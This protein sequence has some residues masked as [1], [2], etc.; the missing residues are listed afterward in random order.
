MIRMVATLIAVAFLISGCVNPSV[1][2]VRDTK[3]APA[4]QAPQSRRIPEP[5]KKDA[6]GYRS[7]DSGRTYSL[8]LKNA[9]IKD[10]L[11]LLSKESGVP[12]VQERNLRGSVKIEAQN[13]KL[14]ELLFIILK[15]LGYTATVENGVIMV[16]RPQL[17]TR[18]FQVN[19]LKDRR[20]S[21]SNMNVA[22]FSAGSVSVSTE[23]TSD[24][25]GAIENSLELMVF[26]TSGKGKRESGGYIRGDDLAKVVAE[27]KQEYSGQGGKTSALV[28]SSKQSFARNSDYNSSSQATSQQIERPDSEVLDQQLADNKLKQLLVNEIAGI[29][30]V[31][32][33]PENIDR[34]AAFLADVEEGS[35]RQVMIQAHIMEVSLKDSFSMG[36]DWKYIID[37]ASNFNL[38][39]T[40]APVVAG[41][42][43][44]GSSVFKLSAAGDSFGVLLDAMKEQGNVNMLSSPKITALNNQKAVIKLTTKQ[45]SWVS[46]KTTQNNAIGG[47]DTY[48]TTPQVDEVGIFLDVTPQIGQ[49]N[50]ITMQIHPS[51]SEIKEI[52]TSPDKNSNKP[53]I[54]VREIDTMVDARAGETIVIAG[55]ITDK[56]NETKRSVPLL[57]DIPYLGALF[58]YSKQ[59]RTKAELVI[60]MTPYILNTKTIAEIREE[61]EQR[62]RNMTGSFYLINNLGSMVSEKSSRDFMNSVPTLPPV[63]PA[64]RAVPS[65]SSLPVAAEPLVVAHAAP[66][67]VEPVVIPDV[68]PA[69]KKSEPP[70]SGVKEDRI[71]PPQP[72]I[73]QLPGRPVIPPDPHTIPHPEKQPR[74]TSNAVLPENAD[75]KR[76][77]VLISTTSP[78]TQ[79]LSPSRKPKLSVPS[80]TS[81]TQGSD[82]IRLE[83]NGPHQQPKIVR[84]TRN[85]RVIIQLPGVSNG[86]GDINVPLD[87]LGFNRARVA[88]HSDGTWVVLHVA[89]K[90][91]PRITPR[92]DEQGMTIM[93]APP[94]VAVAPQ[95][96][97]TAARTANAAVLMPVVPEAPAALVAPPPRE[98]EA[99][100]PDQVRETPVMVQ[101]A[102]ITSTTSGSEQDLYRAGVSAYKAGNCS[103]A[104]KQLSGFMASYPNSPFAADA[105]IYRSD[106]MSR[107]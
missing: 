36:V 33:L 50:S 22:G 23:G 52:S 62:L 96:R 15:P 91:F 103:E 78:Q 107:M 66:K 100:A 27:N 88:R 5:P 54:D 6:D 41:T 75:T 30:Q 77:S 59:E 65:A 38:A 60:M 81:V 67:P 56:L 25:W 69:E 61:H 34:I 95:P 83:V 84:E 40:L 13:K 24:F 29:I 82:G 48:T 79:S 11:M 101:Q 26:G 55:L 3:I 43:T 106:C 63:K 94:I 12:I 7:S 104:V 53:V 99:V 17:A 21:R 45:V 46:S 14:G 8:T 57:G 74:R 4:Y 19:Y 51:V 28:T 42:T 49:D 64:E 39:Q 86:V 37:K 35:K 76:A 105:A 9:D 18:T 90:E 31:T 44:V 1:S 89:G 73:K 93:A 102:T 97:S 58:S 20:N 2:T 16:G 87:L 92:F 80:L 10:V 70:R 71:L 32:D 72:R 68:S 85:Q 47:Q 98:P